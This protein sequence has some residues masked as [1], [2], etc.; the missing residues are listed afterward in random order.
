MKRLSQLPAKDA[1][2]IIDKCT[3]KL[4]KVRGS[5]EEIKGIEL[6]KYIRLFNN[7]S[8]EIT[9]ILQE[10]GLDTEHCEKFGSPKNKLKKYINEEQEYKTKL[11]KNK[12]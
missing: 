2:H 12:K 5:S 10:V 4:V 9:R 8:K 1:L 11:E 6:T 7:N 3:S